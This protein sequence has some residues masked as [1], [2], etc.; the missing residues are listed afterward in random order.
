[1]M[2]KGAQQEQP[3]TRPERKTGK[4]HHPTAS[5]FQTYRYFIVKSS[6][7]DAAQPAVTPAGRESSR[8]S[9][10]TEAGGERAA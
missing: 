10:P 8:S 3:D 6:P 5:L 2:R 4:K 7:G 1:M 9:W